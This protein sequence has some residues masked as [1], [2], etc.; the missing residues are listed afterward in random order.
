MFD[1]TMTRRL[2]LRS[3]GYGALALVAACG[4]APRDDGAPVADLPTPSTPRSAR[5]PSP[6]PPP[7]T[8]SRLQAR[9]GPVARRDAAG[10]G[11]SP[12]GLGDGRDGVLY[13]PPGLDGPAPLVL[14]LHGAGGFARRSIKALL[15]HAD[16][17]GL[18]LLA[19]DSRGRTWDVVSGGFGPDVEFI[20]AAL[21]QTFARVEVDPQRVFVEG[22]S[23]GAS[24]ALS[25]GLS[26]GDLFSA[27]VA[28]S[29]GFTAHDVTRG[30]PRI[31]MSHGT[32]DRVLPIDGTS[33]RIVRRLADEGYD[34]ELVEFA[35]PHDV[36]PPIAEQAVDWLLG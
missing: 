9:P 4:W 7:V 22:F 16:D 27:I 8:A 30:R 12:L 14:A 18:V 1:T 28:F 21:E 23:D 33:R 5:P 13:V 3:I 15:P 26:N 32:A 24:Y 31:W 17:R 20:D 34:V 2:A 35:G 11:M 29:P 19:V 36:P 25:L 6:V 10:S